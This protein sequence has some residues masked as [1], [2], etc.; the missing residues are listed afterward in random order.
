MLSKIQTD[1]RLSG[2]LL[3]QG[4]RRAEPLPCVLELVCAVAAP[5]QLTT[6]ALSFQEL[7]GAFST[8]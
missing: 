6:L 2:R 1:T 8:V 5:L 7:T 3:D 4:T